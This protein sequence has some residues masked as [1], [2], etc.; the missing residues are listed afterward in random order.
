MKRKCILFVLYLTGFLLLCFPLISNV[1]QHRRQKEAIAASHPRAA[2]SDKNH[3]ENMRQDVL[4]YNDMLFQSAGAV[5]NEMDQSLLSDENYNHLLNQSSSGV[6]G[7]LKIPKINVDMPIYHGTSDE[8]L[9]NG[10]GHQQGTSLPMGGENTH[11]VLSGHRGLPGSRLFTRLDELKKEDL[12]FLRVLGETLAY[13]VS[14]IK[15]IEPE[16]VEILNIH[17]GKDLCSLIT[18]TPYGLNTHRLVVTGERVSYKKTEYENIRPAVPSW[19]ELLFT[20]LPFLLTGIALILKIIDWRNAKMKRKRRKRQIRVSAL[21][22]PVFLALPAAVVMFSAVI[23]LSLSEA[24]PVRASGTEGALLVSPESSDGEASLLPEELLPKAENR[25]G[26]ISV[27]LS[28][29]KDGTSREGVELSCIKAA[30]II[31]GLYVL[32]EPYSDSGIDLNNLRNAEELEQ[33]AKKL[34]MLSAGGSSPDGQGDAENLTA[35]ITKF[36]GRTD[37]WGSTVFQD[38]EVGVYLIHAENTDHYDNIT[39][40]LIS[41]PTWDETAKEMLYEITVIPKHTPKPKPEIPKKPAPQT[42]ISSPVFWYFGGAAVLAILSLLLNRYTG[43]QT[44]GSSHENRSRR[45]K[46]SAKPRRRKS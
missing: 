4:N 43:K 35:S 32:D 8:V 29:G 12:F 27:T 7:S 14:E 46:P 3:L 36:S 18:C 31:H 2:I 10:A 16:D 20:A 40:L 41:V 11:C 34:T 13:K 39:P 21:G 23:L 38:L 26:Q 19:R 15:V 1:V 37:K 44:A 42:G 9:S 24:V 25:K 5:V 33:A 28:D 17:A 45:T 6:M 22:I 30:S